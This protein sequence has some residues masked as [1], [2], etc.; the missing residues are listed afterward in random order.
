MADITPKGAVKL[1]HNAILISKII[2]Q[3]ID[4]YGYSITG[5]MR[6]RFRRGLKIYL[7]VFEFSILLTGHFSNNFQPPILHISTSNLYVDLFGERRLQ[8]LHQKFYCSFIGF[9]KMLVSSLLATLGSPARATPMHNLI[10][11]YHN[12]SYATCVS[13][14]DPF[15]SHEKIFKLRT[16]QLL[17]TDLLRCFWCHSAFL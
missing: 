1:K 16:E 7:S 9:K 12:L 6:S 13:F 5:V 10:N 3:K 2:F 11:K 17:F 4:C 15:S 8:P 14:Y